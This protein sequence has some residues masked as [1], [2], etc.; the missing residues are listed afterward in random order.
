MPTTRAT[1]FTPRCSCPAC[2][3]LR[4]LLSTGQLL[5]AAL[6]GPRDRFALR[7]DE[8]QDFVDRH[9]IFAHRTPPPS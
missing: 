2:T 3:A 4:P 5:R 8:E 1:A 6:V 9:S 7:S